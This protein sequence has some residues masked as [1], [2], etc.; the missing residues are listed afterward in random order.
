VQRKQ[1]ER[2]VAA[3]SHLRGITGIPG[4]LVA[5]IFA[6]GNWRV[7]PFA[8][9]LVVVAALAAAACAWYLIERAYRR[10][11]GCMT[12][13]AGTELR[14]VVSMA[15]AVGLVFGGA[16]LLYGLELPVNPIMVVFPVAFVALYA[17]GGALRPHHLVI[18][19]AV[20]VA[21]LLPVWQAPPDPANVALVICGCAAIASGLLDHLAFTRLFASPAAD[22]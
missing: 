15:L 6:L 22:G 13:S 19:G 16:M 9:D 2:R 3:Y 21:G 5:V 17:I 1:L 4:G 8:H 18:W 7:G 14:T 12:R 10:R 11:Y 20:L